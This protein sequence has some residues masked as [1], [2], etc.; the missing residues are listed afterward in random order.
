MFLIW[1]YISLFNAKICHKSWKGSLNN[2]C[3]NSK[4]RQQYRGTLVIINEAVLDRRRRMKWQD[5]AL[6]SSS[7]IDTLSAFFS[8]LVSAIHTPIS[9]SDAWEM[10]FL[11]IYF[12][13]MTCGYDGSNLDGLRTS[14]HSVWTHVLLEQDVSFTLIICLRDKLVICQFCVF[15]ERLIEPLWRLRLK[16][17]NPLC[18]NISTDRIHG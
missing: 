6:S 4:K 13:E 7:L 2:P 16:L 18:W 14:Q 12:F 17:T 10:I 15:G 8:S 1:C 5:D 11:S 9:N 3:S